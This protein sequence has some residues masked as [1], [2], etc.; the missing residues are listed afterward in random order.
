MSEF[1]GYLEGCAAENPALKIVIDKAVHFGGVLGDMDSMMVALTAGHHRAPDF[2]LLRMAHAE[3]KMSSAPATKVIA[4]SVAPEIDMAGG[5][6]GDDGHM[7]FE[8]AS[9]RVWTDVRK[10][11]D[12][13]AE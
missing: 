3:F 11:S 10:E 8:D 9:G 12:R 1:K 7:T 4:Q 6:M 13:D 2:H 5:E